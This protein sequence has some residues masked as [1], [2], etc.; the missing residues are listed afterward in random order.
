VCPDIDIQRCP[1]CGGNLK[2]IAAIE[3]PVVIER[4]LTHPGLCA[5]PPPQAVARRVD[6]FQAA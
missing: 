1:Q 2:I 3:E 6:I 5:Q 4:V